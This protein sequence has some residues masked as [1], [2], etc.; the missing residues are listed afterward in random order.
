[1]DSTKDFAKSSYGKLFSLNNNDHNYQSLFS[2]DHLKSRINMFNYDERISPT[3]KLNSNM[4]NYINNPIAQRNFNT[5]NK[6]AY[7]VVPSKFSKQNSNNNDIQDKYSNKMKK[8]YMDNSTEDLYDGNEG[9]RYNSNEKAINKIRNNENFNLYKINPKDKLPNILMGFVNNNDYNNN[10]KEK[11]FLN[12][13]NKFHTSTDIRLKS[14]PSLGNIGNQIIKNQ[15]QNPILLMTPLNRNNNDYFN[16]N[17]NKN[18]DFKKTNNI[19]DNSIDKTEIN[20]NIYPNFKTSSKTYNNKDQNFPIIYNNANY[21]TF[22]QIEDNINQNKKMNCENFFSNT[23]YTSCSFL[24]KNLNYNSTKSAAKDPSSTL[25]NFS[26]L[27]FKPDQGYKNHNNNN[28]SYKEEFYYNRDFKNEQI[29]EH[30][31]LN[32]K[33]E[34]FE[35]DN[36]NDNSQGK[37]FKVDCYRDYFKEEFK[38]NLPNF[39]GKSISANGEEYCRQFRNGMKKEIGI[40]E[41]AGSKYEGEFLND[42]KHGQGIEYFSNGDI[43]KGNYFN[44]NINGKGIE[45]Y[46]NGNIYK[47]D[48]KD[49]KRDG[50]GIF[51][52]F[53]N[54]LIYE[55]E[56]RN[57]KKN[58]VGVL[59]YNNG[60]V[61]HGEFKE[62]QK[63]GFGICYYKDGSIFEGEFASGEKNGVGIAHYNNGDFYMGNYK[64]NLRHGMGIYEKNQGWKYEGEFENGK[65]NGRGVFIFENGDLYEGEFSEGKKHGLGIYYFR[66]GDIF[67]GGFKNNEFEGFGEYTFYRTGAVYKG[68]FKGGKRHGK[69]FYYGI[70]Y[71]YRVNSKEGYKNKKV[72]KINILI[73]K[74]K[75]NKNNADEEENVKREFN[76]EHNREGNKIDK[77]C[78]DYCDNEK[79]SFINCSDDKFKNKYFDN[80]NNSL[81]DYKKESNFFNSEIQQ[82]NEGKKIETF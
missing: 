8:N 66:N 33:K 11:P 21:Q 3:N 57:N 47:G 81:S 70:S 2:D 58:G 39:W 72:K 45:Y 10:F 17:F 49:N 71:Y 30:K 46:N 48:F 19:S 63:S 4:I 74:E 24:N 31:Q 7:A 18:K 37:G 73:E 65:S 79:E 9:G 13:G 29:R 42:L 54:C 20:Y 5:E 78:R 59:Y 14:L 82:W 62:G 55:G 1:M 36:L 12:K 40:F 41:F 23:H 68:L 52:Y 80:Q 56:F 25:T 67:V 34:I 51:E 75:L 35:G 61:F 6:K 60:A 44:D 77:I 53:E 28:Y 26:N 43:Y 32:Y 22:N 38:Q 69:G 27:N 16:H 76:C 50:I 64:N 15:N